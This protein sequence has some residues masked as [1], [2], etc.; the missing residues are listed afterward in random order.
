MEIISVR[1]MQGLVSRFKEFGP[2]CNNKDLLKAL[3]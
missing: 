1:F 3:S 2:Y